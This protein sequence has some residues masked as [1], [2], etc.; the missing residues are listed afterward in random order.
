MD[1]EKEGIYNSYFDFCS[2]SNFLVLGFTPKGVEPRTLHGKV[3]NDAFV[4]DRNGILVFM[5]QWADSKKIEVM[6]DKLLEYK[7]SKKGV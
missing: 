5:S 4:V 7:K 6:I 3:P 1:T 2:I